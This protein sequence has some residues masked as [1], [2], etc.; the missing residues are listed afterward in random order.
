VT[1]QPASDRSLFIS[2][3][4]EISLAAHHQVSRLT[5][6]LEGERG[7]LNLHP[8]FASVLI[9]FDPR[10]HSHEDIEALARE[11]MEAV[12]DEAREARVVEI[13]VC[14]GG[15]FGPD[16]EEVARHAGLAPE[17]VVELHAAA[18][19]L[20]YFVGFATCFPYLGGLPPELATPRLPAPRKHVPAGSVA[21]GGSQ[22]GI[23]PL[24]SPGGWRIIG[25]TPLRLFDPQAS[26]PPLLRMGDRVRFVPTCGAG[27]YPAHRF[28]TG[29]GRPVYQRSGRVTNPPQVADLPHRPANPLPENIRVLSPGFQTT[30][31]DLGRFG[32]THFGVSASGAADP[33]ALRA[34]NLLVGNAENAAALEMTLV[35]GSFEFETDAA[36]ALTGSDFGAGLPLWTALEIKAGQTVRCGATRSGARAYLAVRGGI[37]V[38]K[39]MGSASVH[40][41]TGVG[42]RPLRAGDALSI[43]DAA[44]RRPR[45]VGPRGRPRA[46]EF[47]RAGPLRVTPG[48]QAHWFSDELYAAAYRVAEE[49]NRMGIRLRGPAIPS[50]AG[51]MLTEGVPLGAI[52]I[53]PDGQPIILF[54]EHQTTGGYPKPANVISADFWRLGE[55]RPRD[56]V[57]FER[58]T[59]EQ[60]LD[61]LREQE[62]WLYALV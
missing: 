27:L 3:G 62:Q 30:V 44:I 42:G 21:I 5:H 40:V 31:Q 49:S 33:L 58:V 38:P 51:H 59:L 52:Q 6:A 29:A 32:Y 61:L 45:A 17:R 48:P 55:L 43:G 28:S 2:F 60:A 19:Y 47:A 12:R 13:P 36:I 14:Y 57:R 41:M 25:R 15:E 1:I 8:A 16:L 10:F 26:P 50:P 34:G 35:G 37:G 46:P 39:A 11:R 20:V 53:P 22:A 9:D 4:D 18:D 54:V 7:V 23:Y 56:E 24:A